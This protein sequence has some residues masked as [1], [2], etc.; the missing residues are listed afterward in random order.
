ME[1]K[2]TICQQRIKLI[3][4]SRLLLKILADFQFGVYL[5]SFVLNHATTHSRDR[6][7]Q[8]YKNLEVIPD[9]GVFNAYEKKR[10]S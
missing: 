9:F 10:K 6:S 4:C 2:K 3:A 5:Q 8:F 1:L 7:K